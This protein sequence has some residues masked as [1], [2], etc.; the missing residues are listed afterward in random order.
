MRILLLGN[1]F[2][3]YN[4]M[5]QMLA[6]LLSAEV[7][8]HTRGGATLREHLNPE[9]EL[10]QK[11]LHALREESWDFVVLQEQSIAP[12][13]RREKFLAS[14]R[15]LCPLIR[16]AGA[17][18]VLYATWAYREGSEKLAKTGLTYEQ[19]SRALAESYRAAAV[20]NNAL[21]AEVGT[22]FDQARARFELYRPEDDYHPTLAGS[23]LIAQTLAETIRTA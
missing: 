3:F 4:D 23:H 21:L 6:Q 1:S 17:Q 19:M 12:V 14:V 11:T 9:T 7:I 16:Q 10:G 20:E 18:P 22:K 5:P 2:T 13:T 15:E 8:A